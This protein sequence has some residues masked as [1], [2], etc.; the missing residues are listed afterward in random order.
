[1]HPK[2]EKYPD[3]EHLEELFKPHID[4][5]DHFIQHGL[6]KMLNS[7]K[8]VEIRNSFTGDK[9][10]N[11]LLLCCFFYIFQ[12]HIL[13]FQT[14]I[15]F[16]SLLFEV[17]ILFVLKLPCYTF[18][19]FFFIFMTVHVSQPEIILGVKKALLLLLLLLL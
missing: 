12:L 19:D 18:Y 2:M 4:S 10:R 16:P 14:P 13:L 5:Y 17:S 7:I 1:M 11:I 8:P 9:L 15:Q 6:E 3:F